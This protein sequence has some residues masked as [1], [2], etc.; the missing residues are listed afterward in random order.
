[1]NRSAISP[2]KGELTHPHTFWNFKV[3]SSSTWVYFNNEIQAYLEGADEL[4]SRNGRYSA[5]IKAKQR[6]N[7]QP[8]STAEQKL[9]ARKSIHGCERQLLKLMGVAVTVKK[10]IKYR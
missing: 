2:C 10:A 4:T 5:W 3:L 7:R 6:K 1:V 9:A 8:E